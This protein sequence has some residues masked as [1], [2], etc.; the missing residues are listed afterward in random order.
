MLDDELRERLADWV[1]PVAALAIPDVRVL[2]RRT[3]RR[4]MRRAATA[5][6]ATAA[7]AAVVISVTAAIPA[8]PAPNHPANPA[9]SPPAWPKAPGS[10]HPG[11][12]RAAGPLP[13]AD[14]GPGSAPYI[15]RLLPG[16]GTAQVRN[17]FTGQTIQ[18]IT[19]PAGQSFGEITAAGDGRT[20]VLQASVGGTANGPL[21]VNPAAAAFDELRLRPDGH[22][23][24]LS[25]LGTVPAKTALSGFAI[26]PDASML[27][28]YT[29]NG[30]ETV[31]LATG[32]GKHWGSD[33][34]N[35]APLSLSW[36]GD[37][38][39]AFQWTAVNSPHPPGN[40]VRLLD[41]AAPGNLLQASRLAVRLGQYCLNDA[42][43]RSEPAI[44]AD[45]SKVVVTRIAQHGSAGPG[46]HY[47]SRVAEYSARTGKLLATATP[48]VTSGWP[49]SLCVAI[50]SSP[51][52]GQVV[53][54]C[55]GSYE[56]Y[57]HGHVTPIT[58]YPPR[59][60]TN[61]V[62]FAWVGTLAADNSVV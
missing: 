50:W 36:A 28:Y 57:D 16:R 41:V 8:R 40:G 24:S 25:V 15:V 7:V 46:S 43:C 61:M 1:R 59:Y 17:M 39:L 33:A 60:G 4:R 44:T 11:G 6:V 45:G 27:A 37:R 38:T 12:W 13:A 51:D 56:R 53:S 22:L 21:P 19:A 9:V 47:T 3:R 62:V 30:I 34:G 31:A 54:F 49:A 29:G 26:S 32:T 48:S 18:T 20:F 14:A 5:A 55:G 42:A 10:W 2:R 35:V 52:G 58:I 23:A